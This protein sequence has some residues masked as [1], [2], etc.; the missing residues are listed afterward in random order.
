[1]VPGRLV[2]VAWDGAPPVLADR[3]F[4]LTAP[5]GAQP[6]PVPPAWRD[7]FHSDLQEPSAGLR[8]SPASLWTGVATGQEEPGVH[9]LPDERVAGLSSPLGG[10]VPLATV[11]RTFMPGRR[12]AV[13]A[14]F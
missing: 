1:P 6:T 4:R 7:L 8:S 11:L 13:S 9:A 2:V 10:D 14:S 12:V 3:W 5:L